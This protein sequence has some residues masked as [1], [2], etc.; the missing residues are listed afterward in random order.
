MDADRWQSAIQNNLKRRDQRMSSCDDAGDREE[1]D[2]DLSQEVLRRVMRTVLIRLLIVLAACAAIAGAIV[3]GVIYSTP[4]DV[5]VAIEEK[6]RPETE[7]LAPSPLHVRQPGV[8]LASVPVPA[9]SEQLQREAEHTANELRNR[10]PNSA[11]ALHVVAMMHSQLRHTN[12]AEKLWQKCIELSPQNETYYVNLAA[13]MMDRGNSQSAI[14]ILQRAI[15]AGSSSPDVLHHLA[16][17]LTNLGKFEE[18]EDAVQK[19]LK[20]EPHFPSAWLVLGQAQLKLRTPAEAEVS[21]RNA[22]SQG[23]RSAELYFALAGACARQGKDQEAAEF[24]KSFSELTASQPLDPQQ[25]FQILSAAEARRTTVAV[26]TEAA[27]IHN[28]QRDSLEAERL[29]LRA[30]RS[31]RSTPGAARHWQTCTRRPA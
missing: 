3:W 19:V 10:Y 31:T 30:I 24:R 2:G 22:M 18:A 21:L 9:T 4:V 20:V 5:P 7:A 12:E 27:F 25:R 1:S 6:A 16:V 28:W 23:V 13:V 26:L 29:L 17:A 11:E 15:S 8:S 14:E